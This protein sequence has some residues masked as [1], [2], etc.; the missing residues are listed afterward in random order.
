MAVAAGAALA[1]GGTGVGVGGMGVEKDDMGVEVG[2][3]DVEV[4]GTGVGVGWDVA[5]AV[6]SNTITVR[7]TVCDASLFGFIAFSSIILRPRGMSRY[8]ENKTRP[9]SRHS[10]C[11]RSM[12]I[13]YTCSRSVPLTLRQYLAIS[14]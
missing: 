11:E 3:T 6:I 5:H 9:P 8:L 13:I 12:G 7:P 10:H 4:G 1:V 14:K 2:G